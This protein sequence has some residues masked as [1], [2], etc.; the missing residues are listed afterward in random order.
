MPAD[1][2]GGIQV[3]TGHPIDAPLVRLE[4][5]FLERQS[6]KAIG[7][8]AL[9]IHQR[10]GFVGE[11]SVVVVD[12]RAHHRFPRLG[13]SHLAVF[14]VRRQLPHAARLI[15]LADNQRFAP[16]FATNGVPY[17][18][19]AS[20]SNPCATMLT[21]PNLFRPLDLGFVTLP[22]RIVMGSMHT[23]LES[24]PDGMERLPPPPPP[25]PAPAGAPPP[26]HARASPPRRGRGTPAPLCAPPARGGPP[27]F[28]GRPLPP[29]RPRKPGPAPPPPAFGVEGG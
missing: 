25:P 13:P 9:R 3:G 1:E 18:H 22:N 19:A 23:Q 11:P 21:Y 26:A 2:E 24:R 14:P 16:R 27:P 28:A 29:P 17:D 7:G 15:G 4:L 6:E 12:R 10:T 5:A 8:T 20:L